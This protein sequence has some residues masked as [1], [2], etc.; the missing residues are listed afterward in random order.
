MNFKSLQTLEYNKII[1]RLA[2]YAS[3]DHAKLM[4]E[5]L[6]PMTDITD[7]F[8]NILNQGK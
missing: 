3:S 6:I 4:A 7:C 2:A 5:K 8:L 1:E